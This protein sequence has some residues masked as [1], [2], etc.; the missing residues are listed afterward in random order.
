MTRAKTVVGLPGSAT[1]GGFVYAALFTNGTIKV[2]STNN[3][4]E[5]LPEH[6]RSAAAFDIDIDDWWVSDEHDDY[7][8]TEQ[9]LIAAVGQ[10]GGRRSR[11]E[12]FQGLQFQAVVQAAR[13]I[14]QSDPNSS[15]QQKL[16]LADLVKP[17]LETKDFAAAKTAMVQAGLTPGRADELIE[18]YGVT[19]DF[20]G[21][22]TAA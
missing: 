2:G 21:L 7:L 4:A 16:S 14:C 17:H 20:P 12:Y 9:A 10:M 3:P 11:R 1:I 8:I 19:S 6:G 5:R 22:E 13:N 18:W 15:W